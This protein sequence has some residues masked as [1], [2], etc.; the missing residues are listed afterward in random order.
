MRLADAECEHRARV[1]GEPQ[2][3]GDADGDD[4]GHEPGPERG[5]ERGPDAVGDAAENAATS[6]RATA[7]SVARPWSDPCRSRRSQRACAAVMA[8]DA[9]AVPITGPATPRGE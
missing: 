9:V 1:D 2:D 7:L 8:A 6:M 4:L 5:V 3:D